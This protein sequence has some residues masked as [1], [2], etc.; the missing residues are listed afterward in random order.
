MVRQ[1]CEIQDTG[2]HLNDWMEQTIK[3]KK[4]KKSK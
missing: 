2:S 1:T 4:E 3:N